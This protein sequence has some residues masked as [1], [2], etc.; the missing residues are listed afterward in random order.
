MTVIGKRIQACVAGVSY[1]GCCVRV[2]GV[3][4]GQL[5]AR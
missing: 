5:G 4:M 2:E 3:L 1:L